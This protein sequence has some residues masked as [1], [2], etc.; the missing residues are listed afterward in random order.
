[1]SS[2]GTEAGVEVLVVGPSR[3][4]GG[5]VNRYIDEQRR[6]L[7]DHVRTRVY[8]VAV[9]AGSGTARFGLA[10]L[11]ALRQ[12]FL[13]P[14]RRPP[15]VVHV[16]TSHWHSFYQS[17]WYVFFAAFVW[18][19]PVVLHVHGSSFDEFLE[20][21]S[22]IVRALQNAVFDAS[23]V[24]VA[25]S[26]GWAELIGRRVDPRKVTVLHNAV[27]VSEYESS[28]S[29]SPIRLSFVSNHVERKGIEELV[30]AIDRLAENGPVEAVIAGKGPESHLA[31]DLADARP[32]VEYVG[33]V[34]E[35]RKRGILAES[36]VYVLPTYAE[37]VPIA[38]LEAMAAG[39]AIVSTAVGGIPSVVDDR[40][41]V[42]VEPGDADALTDA[43]RTLLEDPDSV[44]S[45][46]RESRRRVERS[47]S[48]D[49][50]TEELVALYYSFA[51]SPPSDAEPSVNRSET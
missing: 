8:S 3:P 24:V 26:D 6:H 21:D 4:G 33:F 42:L 15:D 35:E 14:F 18:R 20:T 7:P 41:G 22:R 10:V 49:G 25:L 28:F 19:R 40:N 9:P 39:N 38:I 50:V 11:V 27:D 36:S 17:S 32:G 29:T 51:G 46:A 48:W 12:M 37:G 45:M 47:H 16:H 30:S 23:D 13:F 44:E 2:T 31:A 34:S 5:G 1:M 43:I